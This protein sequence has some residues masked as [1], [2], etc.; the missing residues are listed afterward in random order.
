MRK[1]RESLLQRLASY[2][3]DVLGITTDGIW[4][5]NGRSYPHILPE[6][7][8]E[9]NILSPLRGAFWTVFPFRGWKLHGDFHHLNSSQ[10]M[11]FNLFLPLENAPSRDRSAYLGALGIENSTDIRDGGEVAVRFEFVPDIE[12]GTNFDFFLYEPRTGPAYFELK[13]SESEFGAACDCDRHRKKLREI[14]APRLAGLV[15]AEAL[16]PPFFFR[17]YQLLRNTAALSTSPRATVHVVYPLANEALEGQ[18]EEFRQ[19]LT[20]LARA[21][22]R[23]HDLEELVQRLRGRDVSP[24][25]AEQLALFHRKYL[26]DAAT[27]A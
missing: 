20:P 15:E 7:R 21:R 27:E 19:V 8:R 1:Y 9:E 26:S 11:C 4:R 2:K 12:E 25:L 14:Y 10:A 17:N 23:T 6:D 16:E 18:L 5:K 24:L 13:L 22:F 3:R